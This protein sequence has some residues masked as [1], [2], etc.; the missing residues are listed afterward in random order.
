MTKTPMTES[1]AEVGAGT[2]P[3][4]RAIRLASATAIVAL[5]LIAGSTAQADVVETFDLSGSFQLPA[6][7]FSGTMNLDFTN[8]TAE[9]VDIT[10][11]GLPVY[12]QS[13]SLRFATF[14]KEAVVDVLDSSGEMLTLD[15]AIPKLGTLAGFTGGRIVGGLALFD[16]GTEIPG[17]LFNPTGPITPD[18]SNPPNPVTAGAVPEPSTWVMMLLGFA[19]LGAAACSRRAIGFLAGKA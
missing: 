4:S 19:G 13:P 9:S 11:N 17:F 12:N 16:S 8:E 2:V 3:R 1:G 7:T 6:L 14:T 15:F 18:P 10:V 5:A